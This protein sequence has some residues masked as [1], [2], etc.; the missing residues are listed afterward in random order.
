MLSCDGASR[1][2]QHR[3]MCKEKQRERESR[4]ETQTLWLVLSRAKSV[5]L[6][7]EKERVAAGRVANGRL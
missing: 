1:E 2:W 6:E 7:Q 4:K 5:G 3:M